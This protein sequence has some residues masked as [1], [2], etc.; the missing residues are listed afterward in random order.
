MP[1][2]AKSVRRPPIRRT[3]A[4]ETRRE[5]KRISANKRAKAVDAVALLKE[6]H[7]RVDEMFERFEK[8]RNDGEQKAALVKNICHKLKVHTTVEEEI[9][10][11]AMREALRDEDLLDE[12]DIEHASAKALIAQLESMKPGDDHYDAKVTVLGEYIRHHVKEEQKEMFPQARK[13]KVDLKALG[14]RIAARKAELTGE[15]SDTAF[16]ES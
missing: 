5:Q 7:Q 14:A 10:Y 4:A 15:G 9:F 16:L 13:A 12:A 3:R 2:S 6:D 11:P 8:M 1:A